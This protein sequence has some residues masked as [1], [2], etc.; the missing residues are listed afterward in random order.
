M[1]GLITAPLLIG[2]ILLYFV[3]TWEQRRSRTV[4][5]T[6]RR[7]VLREKNGQIVEIELARTVNLFPVRTPKMVLRAAKWGVEAVEKGERAEDPK[8]QRRA[9]E[10]CCR[11]SWGA[12]R[13]CG[14]SARCWR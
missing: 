11:W 5:V 14:W 10:R 7:L 6:K 3:F 12:W 1:P 2:L 13:C 8:L 9:A 4:L